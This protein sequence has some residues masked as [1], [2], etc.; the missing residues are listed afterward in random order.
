MGM[1]LYGPQ[2]YFRTDGGTWC[3]WLDAAEEHGWKPAGT[4]KPDHCDGE[5][6][7]GYD[8][9]DYQRVTDEDAKAL[10]KALALTIPK[11]PK[12]TIRDA[13]YHLWAFIGYA[14]Q[15]GFCIG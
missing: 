2:G 10:S 14:A 13:Y 5:W 11:I 9:N 1:D 3:N 4:E 7:G 15:G 12:E 8:S 6:D